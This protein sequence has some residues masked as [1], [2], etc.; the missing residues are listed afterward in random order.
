MSNLI[1]ILLKKEE[2]IDLDFKEKLD[3][4]NKEQKAELSKDVS[5]IANSVAKKGYLVIGISDAKK[6]IGIEEKLDEEKIQLICERRIT[7]PVNIEVKTVSFKENFIGIIEIKPIHKPHKISQ[8]SGRLKKEDVYIRRGS[9]IRKASPEEIIAMARKGDSK[10][11][12]IAKLYGILQRREMFL[13]WFYSKVKEHKI[14]K[15]EYIIS[16]ISSSLDKD[17]ISKLMRLHKIIY[18]SEKDSIEKRKDRLFES[19]FYDS[20]DHSGFHAKKLLKES[21]LVDMSFPSLL[22]QYNKIKE[23]TRIFLEQSRL[24]LSPNNGVGEISLFSIVKK[25]ISYDEKYDEAYKQ[26]NSSVNMFK[27]TL[28]SDCG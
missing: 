17:N 7:P 25:D 13:M 27:K 24:Y 10:S 28:T 2:G 12:K 14:S 3:I 4:N 19:I 22:S 15:I 8:D 16:E 9:V 5:S 26:V 6:I 21:E 20:A 11:K 1:E 18:K 23:E